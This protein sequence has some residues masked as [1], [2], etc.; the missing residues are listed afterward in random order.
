VLIFF[1]VLGVYVANI[2]SL[3]Y[4][5]G[6]EEARG[7]IALLNLAATA[8]VLSTFT[9]R[10]IFPLISLEGKKF[11][12]L[13]LAPVERRR[14]LYGKYFF[15]F[16][17]S[18]AVSEALIIFSDWMLAFPASV[19]LG[20]AVM[21]LAICSGLAAVSVGLGACYPNL[22][23]DNPARIVAGFGGTLNLIVS[24]LYI[25]LMVAGVAMPFQLFATRHGAAGWAYWR[26]FGAYVAISLSLGTLVTVT[27]LGLGRSRFEKLEF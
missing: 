1:G 20:H 7:G 8:L 13:G 24:M 16:F 15:A 4:N 18:L 23:E 19:M 5:L 25:L 12:V 3:P 9:G 2:R 22:K 11:W 17:G 26:I 6:I 10:F 14:I 21:V 27:F